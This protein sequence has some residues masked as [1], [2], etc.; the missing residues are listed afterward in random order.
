MSLINWVSWKDL[1]KLEYLFL[2][3]DKEANWA[4]SDTVISISVMSWNY[5]NK[6]SL[7]TV[8]VIVSMPRKKLS[9]YNFAHFVI[10]E[11]FLKG[12]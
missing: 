6:S 7:K 1:E 11:R 8:L 3:F 9:N 4:V 12:I 10:N 2:W 5:P